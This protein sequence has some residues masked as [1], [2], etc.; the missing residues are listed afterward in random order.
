MRKISQLV[1]K[2]IFRDGLYYLFS[3]TPPKKSD[4]PPP[5]IT[6]SREMGAGGRPIAYLVARKLGDPW[7]VYHKEIVDEIAKEANLEKKLIKEFEEKEISLIDQ[8]IADFF[9]KRYLSMDFYYKN[10]VKVLTAIGAHG[11]AI[12]LGRGAS[13]LFPHALRVRIISQKEQRIAW[14]M[15]FEKISRKEAEKRIEESDKKRVGFIKAL[16]DCDPGEAHHYDLVIKTGLDL[17][18]NDTA[19]LIVRIAK[20]RFKL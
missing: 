13:H 8:F 18:I 19:D 5:L 3:P 17:S 7:R 20:R 16:Y 9:G 6:I 15:E 4:E 1:N 12:I 11:Y 14:E 2:N 10:L